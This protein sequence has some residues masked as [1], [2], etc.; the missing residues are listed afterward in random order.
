MQSRN[1]V[2]ALVCLGIALAIEG[3]LYL[4]TS[5]ETRTH[6]A[7]QTRVEGEIE[8]TRVKV[9]GRQEPL[10]AERGRLLGAIDELAAVLPKAAAVD[11]AA[12]K[13]AASKLAEETG[14]ALT[15]FR[16]IEVGAG[17][18]AVV[19]ARRWRVVA[20]GSFPQVVGFLN[21]L[22][23]RP[24]FYRIDGLTLAAGGRTDDEGRPLL[25]L[26]ATV[27]TFITR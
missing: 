14:V 8:A 11:A 24:S 23:N 6:R 3:V 4:Q 21:R 20:H 17:D 26:S 27:S 9:D 13:A 2:I 1:S 7:E 15:S 18:D 5:G 12:A 25:N 19:S 10:E 16:A 22:E